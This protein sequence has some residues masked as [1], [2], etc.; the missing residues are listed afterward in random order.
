MNNNLRTST[1]KHRVKG[2]FFDNLLSHIE[3]SNR[4]R[5]YIF[6]VPLI[7]G[8]LL[9]IT[10]L[11][12]PPGK[13]GVPALVYFIGRFHPLIIHFPIV[14]ILLVLVFEAL[15]R[16]SLVKISASIIN[17]LLLSA[18]LF[19]ALAVMAGFLLYYTGEYSGDIMVWH[20]WAGI[21]VGIGTLLTTFFFLLAQH[22][23][24]SNYN[25]I[26]LTLL[27]VTNVLLLYASHQGGS[28]T[29]GKEYLTE[30][31]P[32][33]FSK[34]T[35]V[36]MK[37]L[38]EM[39]IYQ[40]IMVPMLDAK[41]MSCHNENKTKGDLMMTTYEGLM[42]GGKSEM[43]TVFPNDAENS[44]IYHRVTL[45][46][47]DDEH[48]P[49]EGKVPLTHDEKFL[50]QWW[51]NK[52]ASPTLTVREADVDSVTQSV[53]ESYL[54]ELT[55]LYVTRQSREK[56]MEALM[57]IAGELEKKLNVVIQPDPE[58]RN[59][60]IIVSMQFPP[61]VFGD[62]ELA[63][64]TPLFSKISKLSLVGSNITDDGLYH[65]SKMVNLKQ[66][67]LQQ[68]SIDGTGLIY[69]TQ[70]PHLEHLNLS[71]TAVDDAGVLNILKIP[72]LKE[73]YLNQTKVSASL[74]Q[75]LQKND[76]SL[77]VQLDRGKYF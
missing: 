23:N 62:H 18:S 68:T 43:A 31:M 36:T 17:I 10:L 8:I 76:P 21:G 47:S 27:C 51:I 77:Q 26:Y 59:E 40:D 60:S 55:S 73:V 52:G 48:M 35:A 74:V 16:L 69:L 53:L 37:P 75:A 66:L 29:H 14:L 4:A 34:E 39:I 42:T 24:S 9:F 49:P 30:Y 50:L 32:T 56:E 38:E 71:K 45:P 19:C 22:P 20:K 44:G 28:L 7:A 65:I 61:A 25:F 64:L 54:A 11:Y 46:E 13:D 72:S 67:I 58:T 63:Q 1:L 6:Y 33:W 57:E 15:S 5:F 12:V 2:K 41:C 3:Q 70:L